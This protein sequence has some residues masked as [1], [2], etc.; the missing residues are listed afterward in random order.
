MHT[1]LG[2]TMKMVDTLKL[3][4]AQPD[5]SFDQYL[6]EKRLALGESVCSRARIYLDSKYW[7]LLRN[8]AMGVENDPSI[9]G[10]LTALREGV[11]S[12]RLLC[13]VGAD[14]FVEIL[15]QTN[16]STLVESVRL[17]DQLSEGV[18]VI[19]HEERVLL[20]LLA[21]ARAG[22]PSDG[23]YDPK[24]LAWT[25][26]SFVLGFRMPV[27]TSFTR[28]QHEA[29][30]KAFL[31]LLWG[32]SLADMVETI[33]VTRIREIERG[34]DISTRLNANKGRY[35][36]DCKSYTEAFL[37]EV[38]G[39]LD[40]MRP[41]LQD[42]LCYV[43]ERY[44]ELKMSKETAGAPRS[45]QCFANLIY[46]SFRLG[47]LSTELPFIRI[48]AAIHAAMWRDT[49]RKYKVTDPHDILHA[50]AALPYFH[51]FLTDHSLKHLLTRKDLSLDKLYDCRV[52]SDPIEA[53]KKIQ[54]I[55]KGP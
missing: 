11:A 38:A 12:N 28:Q 25:K 43:A 15:S 48:Q 8:A 45:V 1:R 36:P 10:L 54:K 27:A 41:D 35:G 19:F 14:T 37:S 18:A 33:D 7:I 52:I 51:I 20:E 32:A 34:A 4:L 39:C 47:L 5:K 46:H 49:S 55:V 53:V 9:C 16:E 40:F 50:T 17:I 23:S 24:T 42:V 30:Q 3:H 2:D 44:P 22:L 29:M 26:V 13:P 6:G 21:F 31:D